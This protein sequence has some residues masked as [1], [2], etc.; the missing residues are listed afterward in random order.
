MEV[1]L[2]RSVM[3]GRYKTQ[4]GMEWNGTEPE[5]I[6]IQ[7][8]HGCWTCGQKFAL[9]R[10]VRLCVRTPIS[11]SVTATKTGQAP[12]ESHVKRIKLLR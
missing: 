8:R 10:T 2:S 11:R 6:V 3:R 9:I 12:I 1:V 7:Y 5:V 4:N